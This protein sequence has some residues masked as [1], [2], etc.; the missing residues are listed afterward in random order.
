MNFSPFSFERQSIESLY[1]AATLHLR[2]WAKPNNRDL[3][4]NAAMGLTRSKTSL[5][6]ENTLLTSP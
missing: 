4:L 1:Q 5:V 2:W 6:L 3:V